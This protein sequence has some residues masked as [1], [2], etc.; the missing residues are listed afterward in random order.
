MAKYEEGLTEEELEE[1]V[2][3]S[4]V[5]AE[6]NVC[7]ASRRVEPDAEGYSCFECDAPNSV[8]SPL[9]VLGLM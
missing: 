7:G 6:C 4:V 1:M 8:S 5:D 3:A 9:V 2:T